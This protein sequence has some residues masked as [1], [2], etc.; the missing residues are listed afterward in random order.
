VYDGADT[1]KWNLE[2]EPFVVRWVVQMK[3]DMCELKVIGD[4]IS[5]WGVIRKRKCYYQFMLRLQKGK[6]ID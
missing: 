6:D 1:L 4:H 3:E 2:V 5:P